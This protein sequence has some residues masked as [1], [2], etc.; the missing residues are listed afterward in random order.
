MMRKWR[1]W[2]ENARKESRGIAME[3]NQQDPLYKLQINP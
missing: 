2:D 3:K 1:G